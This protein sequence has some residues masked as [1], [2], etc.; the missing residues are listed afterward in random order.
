MKELLIERACPSN[1]VIAKL[2]QQRTAQGHQSPKGWRDQAW[3]LTLSCIHGKET[4][5]GLAC[6]KIQDKVQVLV[7]V[8]HKAEVKKRKKISFC[9]LKW[10]GKKKDFGSGWAFYFFHSPHRV[11]LLWIVDTSK[12]CLLSNLGQ[13]IVIQFGFMIF[14]PR[15]QVWPSILEVN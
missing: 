3:K 7:S 12:M 9:Q 13:H 1:G 14:T 11:S 6:L 10:E 15:N 8:L 2:V 5:E 4:S